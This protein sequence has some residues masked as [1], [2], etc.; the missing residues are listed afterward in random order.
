MHV[1][2]LIDDLFMHSLL[3]LSGLLEETDG[4]LGNDETIFG[5]SAQ[6]KEFFG[7]KGTGIYEIICSL[8]Y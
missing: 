1:W 7:E 6:A 8:N 2:V 5:L 4:T 3:S